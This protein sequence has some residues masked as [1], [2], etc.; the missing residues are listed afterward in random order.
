MAVASRLMPHLS[1]R[2]AVAPR[3]VVYSVGPAMA[4]NRLYRRSRRA[5]CEPA[6]VK[7][8]KTVKSMTSPIPYL[9]GIVRTSSQTGRV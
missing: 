9:M 8:T 6:M 1:N 5:G 2:G 4:G 7:G 3:S